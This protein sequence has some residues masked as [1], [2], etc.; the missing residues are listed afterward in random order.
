LLLTCATLLMSIALVGRFAAAQEHGGHTA[1]S[2]PQSAV[3][4]DVAQSGATGQGHPAPA[5]TPSAHGEAEGKGEEH[6][7][8]SPLPDPTARDTW[9]SAL[10]VV[11]IFVVLLAILYPTAWKQVLIGLKAREQRIRTDIAEAEAS[12]RKAEETLR[13]YN[14]QLSAAE[15]RIRDM[16]AKAQADGE[17]LATTIRMQAQTEA[18]EIKERAQKDIDAAKN[19]AIGEIYAQAADLSTSIAEKILKRN[20]NADDQRELVRQSLEQ[21]QTVKV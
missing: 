14:D 7:S 2:E 8:D 3:A 17:K 15:G 20:L 4:R 5:G 1:G 6:G 16:L 21:L 9:M 13:Q 11:I 12:R 10:W 19:A 18:E